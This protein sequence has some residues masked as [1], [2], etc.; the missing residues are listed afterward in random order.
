M[1]LFTFYLN[2]PC[3]W[4]HPKAGVVRGFVV[5]HRQVF[6]DKIFILADLDSGHNGHK[7]EWPQTEMAT[8]RNGHI[9]E[10]P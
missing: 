10:R 1:G 4:I 5:K 8:N 9:P 2:P 6:D 3:I 7:P